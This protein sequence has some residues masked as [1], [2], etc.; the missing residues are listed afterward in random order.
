[1]VPTLV[2]HPQERLTIGV[3]TEEPMGFL[4]QAAAIGPEFGWEFCHV[5]DELV[6]PMRLGAALVEATGD[7]RWRDPAVELIRGGKSNLTF[8]VRSDAGELVLRRPPSGNLLPS[9]HGTWSARLGRRLADRLPE[10]RRSSVVHGDYRLDN[11]VLHPTDPATVVAVF[12]GNDAPA[13][14]RLGPL[15][16]QVRTGAEPTLADTTA[17]RARPGLGER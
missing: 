4:G 8:W 16:A 3:P 11:V 13:R 14:R 9:A 7:D 2:G 12:G 1:V 17:G 10:Q 15:R 6:Q 5:Y